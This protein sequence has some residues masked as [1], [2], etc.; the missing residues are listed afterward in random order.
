MDRAVQIVNILSERPLPQLLE[1]WYGR[2]MSTVETDAQ[3]GPARARG[4]PRQ[5]DADEVLDQVMELFWAKGYEATSISDIVATTGLNKSS[6][7]NSFG[8]KDD[9]FAAAVERYLTMRMGVMRE[10]V[11]DGTDGLDDVLR[12]LDFQQEAMGGEHG[13]MGCLA[14]NTSTELGLRDDDAAA[15]S[16]RFRGEI[17]EAVGAAFTRAEVAG[18]IAP[19]TTADRTETVLAF[20]LSLAVISRGGASEA[21]LDG[22]FTAMRA[23]VEDWRLAQG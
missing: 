15:L 18:E 21:E 7:Y 3:A 14:V 1:F 23:L 22:Q 11:R 19:G 10:V 16:R 8:S 9:L 13:R 2:S 17:R 6:L 4:R 12:L 5:F 20:T